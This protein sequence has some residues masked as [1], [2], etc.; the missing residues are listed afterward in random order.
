MLEKI[1]LILWYRYLFKETHQR[2][3]STDFWIKQV[4]SGG[5]NGV[6]HQ[7]GIIFGI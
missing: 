2:G 1:I 3:I 6:F 4:Q 5:K 7:K